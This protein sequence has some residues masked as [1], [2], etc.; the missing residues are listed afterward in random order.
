MKRRLTIILS[1]LLALYLIV[2][3]LALNYA[4]LA[5]PNNQVRILWDN[6]HQQYYSSD[7]FTILIND[8][9]K[10]SIEVVPNDNPL[11]ETDLSLYDVV[12]IPNPRTPLTNEELTS[13]RDYVL[14]GGTL[15]IM[16]D[17]QYDD[18]KYGKPDYLNAIL[19]VLGLTSK[20]RYWGTNDNGDE[21]YSTVDAVVNPWQVL[22]TSEYFKPSI[23][24]VGIKKVVINGASF[25]VFDPNVIVAT[26]SPNAYA[27]DTKSVQH[28]YGKIPWLVAAEVGNGKVVAVCG[29][30]VFSDK[31]VIG[32][33]IPFI[34]YGDNEKLFL[35]IVWWLTGYQP[36]RPS[37]IELFI[38]F[39][40]V[41]GVLTGFL[42][43]Y[44][45]RWSVEKVSRYVFLTGV[46]FA[47]AAALE[48]II[49]GTTV[50][51]IAYPGWGVVSA[52]IATEYFTVPAWA[53]AAGR[54]FFAGLFDAVSGAIIALIALIIRKRAKK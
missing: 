19:E 28:S 6:S 43:A 16:G 23:F 40:D 24:S 9:K 42:V 54:Y 21:I 11:N 36:P 10:V 1:G 17:V 26:T 14:N 48:V 50:F 27:E 3:I 7:L 53:V 41:F 37:K 4:C 31:E 33:G 20:F 29:S 25:E 39:M 15:I 35:N 32:V 30:R 44:A 47:L 49:V 38:P 45:T 2:Y 8:L 18:R 5:Q 22:V 12:V 52:G 13:I 34:S 51:G 46:M